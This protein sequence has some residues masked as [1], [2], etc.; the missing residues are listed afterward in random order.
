MEK[1][2]RARGNQS[3]DPNVIVRGPKGAPRGGTRTEAL[4]EVLARA[5]SESSRE[6]VDAIQTRSEVTAQST[7][8]QSQ[9]ATSETEKPF[10]KEGGERRR[11][12]CVGLAAPT[13]ILRERERDLGTAWQLCVSVSAPSPM[14][15]SQCRKQRTEVSVMSAT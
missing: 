10:Q 7:S 12:G 1:L 3:T 11:A 8:P 5:A 13:R 9:N 15:Q 6:G 2:S 4:G 14:V